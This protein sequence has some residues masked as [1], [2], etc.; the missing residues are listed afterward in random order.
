MSEEKRTATTE[1][2]KEEARKLTEKELEKVSGGAAITDDVYEQIVERK[3][4][5]ASSS[6]AKIPVFKAQKVVKHGVK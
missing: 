4:T 6:D 1:E 2:V 3:E 5:A